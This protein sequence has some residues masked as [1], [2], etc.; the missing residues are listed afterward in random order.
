[1]L[2]PV[3]SPPKKSAERTNRT[4]QNA[5]ESYLRTGDTT[6]DFAEA[7]SNVRQ[8]STQSFDQKDV[9]DGR[10][11]CLCLLLV[12]VCCICFFYTLHTKLL[13]SISLIFL[14]VHHLQL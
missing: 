1:L 7:L 2:L 11:Y 13:I 5:D 9:V 6:I 12:F 14:M 4:L 8:L 3:E 10:V